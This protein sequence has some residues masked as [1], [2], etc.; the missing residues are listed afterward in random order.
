[1]GGSRRNAASPVSV[2]IDSAVRCRYGVRPGRGACVAAGEKGAY[3]F[4]NGAMRAAA[5][6]RPWVRGGG[7]VSNKLICYRCPGDAGEVSWWARSPGRPGQLGWEEPG[8]WVG[9]CC[10]HSSSLVAIATA[11]QLVGSA[12]HMSLPARLPRRCSP[13]T[14]ILTQ[15][16]LTPSIRTTSIRPRQQPAT[17]T[18][19]AVAPQDDDQARRSSAGAAANTNHHQP[20]LPPPTNIDGAATSMAGQYA[21]ERDRL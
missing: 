5:C 14:L 21:Y 8:E 1:M 2:L 11:T 7:A 10:V 4:F 16:P 17:A 20:P 3:M 9:G 12:Q 6:R 15:A 19:L 18:P 13:R